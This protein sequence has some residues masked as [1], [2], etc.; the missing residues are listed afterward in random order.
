MIKEQYSTN[1][2]RNC[3]P[4]GTILLRFKG[5]EK[6][7]EVARLGA[8]IDQNNNFIVTRKIVKAKMINQKWGL[9]K[10]T[11]NLS[12]QTK[13]KNRNRKDMTKESLNQICTA[14]E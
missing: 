5:N 12:E 8:E 3:A 4:L 14:T 10:G 7:D 13:P 11:S 6:A 9:Q 2:H 1:C